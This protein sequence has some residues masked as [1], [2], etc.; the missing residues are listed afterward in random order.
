MSMRRQGLWLIRYSLSPE[1][2]IR[3]VMATSLKSTGRTWSALSSTRVTSATPTGCRADEPEKMTSSMAWPRSCLALCSPS[4]QRIASETFD[5]P[6]PFGPTIT[7]RPGSKVMC[8]RSA[9]DLKP[10]RVRDFRN[11]RAYPCFRSR[12]TPL[13]V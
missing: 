3:R 12:M 5:L 9:K 11:M 10:L 13:V 6:D 7:V 2:Y 4:T 1:R 8:A